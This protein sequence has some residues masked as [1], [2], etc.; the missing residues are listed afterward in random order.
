[1]T[2]KNPVVFGTRP[3]AIKMALLVKTLQAHA[4]FEVKVCSI[5]NVHL[6]EPLDY[7]PF[8]YLMDQST[9]TGQTCPGDARHH[10]APRGGGSGHRQTGRHRCGKNRRA[11]QHTAQ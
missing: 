10:R 3:E 4:A 8:V 1:M 2:K 11:R 5:D 6:I 9:L 7:L